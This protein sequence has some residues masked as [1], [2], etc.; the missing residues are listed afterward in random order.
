MKPSG[1][2]PSEPCFRG[3]KMRRVGGDVQDARPSLLDLRMTDTGT[4]AMI[5]RTVQTMP[6]PVSHITNM[7]TPESTR[8]V[9]APL[10]LTTAKANQARSL[11]AAQSSGGL[12]LFRMEKKLHM[13]PS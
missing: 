3:K 6:K 4:A 13:R 12:P 10:M 7:T 1:G 8:S 11:S 2:Q 9:N 5:M